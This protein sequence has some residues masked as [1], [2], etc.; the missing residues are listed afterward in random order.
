MLVGFGKHAALDVRKLLIRDPSYVQWVLEQPQ[1]TGRLAA[2]AVKVR[3]CIDVFDAKPFVLGCM[4]TER[5]VRCARTVT[6]GTA[7]C[8][9][10]GFNGNMHFWCDECDP[11]QL[12]A[13]ASL[14]D[15]RSYTDA[16]AVASRYGGTK[17]DSASVVKSLARSKGMSKRITAD[18]LSSFFG[19]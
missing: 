5:G 16:I 9:S 6:R 4:G 15:V 7:Y 2:L 1:S 10:A 14:L 12:G 8:S 3:Q 19:L 13:A 17:S 18:A 11:C